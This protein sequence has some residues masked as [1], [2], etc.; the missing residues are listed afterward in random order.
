MITLVTNQTVV[1]DIKTLQQ[2]YVYL[3]VES[4]RF[5]GTEYIAVVEYYY[6]QEIAPA[7][8]DTPAQYRKIQIDRVFSNM[9][10]LQVEAIETSL[11]LTGTFTEH[12]IQILTAACIYKL[13]V[14]PVFG[15]TGNNWVVE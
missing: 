14:D 2:E 8:G 7:E 4:V 1:I 12:F 11:T 15:L 5:T 3:K 13:T 10:I 6:N 9:S